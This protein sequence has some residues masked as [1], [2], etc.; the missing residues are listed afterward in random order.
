MS[1]D[2]FIKE[3]CKLTQGGLNAPKIRTIIIDNL[4][5]LEE[6]RNNLKFVLDLLK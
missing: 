3:S 1:N 6:I 2:Q 4:R 5:Q